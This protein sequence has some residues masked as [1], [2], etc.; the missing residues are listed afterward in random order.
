MV[1][2]SVRFAPLQRAS[3]PPSCSPH[4]RVHVGVFVR[5]GADDARVPIFTVQLGYSAST[6]LKFIYR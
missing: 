4:S 3:R 2:L 6:Q 1:S 5:V